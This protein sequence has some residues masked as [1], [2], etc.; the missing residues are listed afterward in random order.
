VQQVVADTI[1]LSALLRARFHQPRIYLLG[2]SGGSNYGFWAAQQR[3]DLYAAYIGGSQLVN[4]RLTDRASI[5]SCSGTPS[6]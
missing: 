3:P 6:R 1:Q 2:H 4:N 5:R